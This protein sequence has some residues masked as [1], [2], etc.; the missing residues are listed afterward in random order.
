MHLREL[1]L[2]LIQQCTLACV[3]CSTDSHRRKTSALPQNVVLRL[4]REAS[5]LG[6]EK[7]V[8]SGGEPLLVSYLPLVIA[9]A[10]ALRIH[11]SL[12]T[13]GVTDFALNPLLL[14]RATHLRACG[15]GRF[16]FSVYSHNAEIHNSVTRY[17][18]FSTTVE[19]IKSA[20]AS[21]TPTEIHFVAMRRNFRDLAGLVEAAQ[22]WGVARVSVLRFVPHGRGSVIAGRED[23]SAE[24]MRELREII[25]TSRTA[26]P[27]VT[28]RAGSPYNSLEVGYAPCDA[29]QATVSVN[30]RGE[31]FPCDAFKNVQYADHR[32]GSVLTSS[33]K[34]VWENSAFLNR[35]RNELAAPSQEGCGSCSEFSG[36]RS[37]CL[38]Q[39]VIH[40][41]WERNSEPGPGYLVQI[42]GMG[43]EPAQIDRREVALDIH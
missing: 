16:I 2:E 8:F 12:Y 5:A 27:G 36:C 39:K 38:A 37:G 34:E 31:V 6:V 29:A 14:D 10:K 43:G 11:S 23:L 28:V 7:A 30:H 40:D 35:V 26:F 41:G 4:L 13:C 42:A 19:S 15:L 20:V 1:K 18:S 25:L 32:F 22:T 21:G 33:L 24:E 9:E 17:A 3:H